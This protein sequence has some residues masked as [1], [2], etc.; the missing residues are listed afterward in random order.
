MD[1]N[2]KTETDTVLDHH[3]KFNAAHIYEYAV[4]DDQTRFK[5]S[6]VYQDKPVPVEKVVIP[7]SP[8]RLSDALMITEH[9]IQNIWLLALTHTLI[10]PQSQDSDMAEQQYTNEDHARAI[11]DFVSDYVNHSVE[12]GNTRISILTKLLESESPIDI[13]AKF[14]V[15]LLRNGRRTWVP[16]GGDK[17]INP[18]YVAI[19]RE[20]IVALQTLLDYCTNMARRFHP[21]YLVPVKQCFNE[22]ISQYPK[23]LHATLRNTSYIPARGIIVGDAEVTDNID[24]WSF[25]SHRLETYYR[26]GENLVSMTMFT[27]QSLKS[28]IGDRRLRRNWF[29]GISSHEVPRH[30]NQPKFYGVPFPSLVALD[31]PF[32]QLF[33]LAGKNGFENAALMAVLRFKYWQNGVYYWYSRLAMLLIFYGIFLSMVVTHVHKSTTPGAFNQPST[34]YLTQFWLV[35]ITV[36]ISLGCILLLLEVYQLIEG[37]VGFR[38]FKYDIG[39]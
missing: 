12:Y 33:E 9:C 30:R 13:S 5:A 20:N 35:S 2:G 21:L 31:D 25:A 26:Q 22:L 16:R 36:G 7:N 38:Y 27:I 15:S 1:I 14:I 10:S 11:I 6:V 18:I 32:S 28:S 23:Y 37:I 3:F 29:E 17:T 39:I 34:L 8:L 24:S 19:T 4:K